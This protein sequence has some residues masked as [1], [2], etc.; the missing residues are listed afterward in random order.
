MGEPV[1][2]VAKDI[3]SILLDSEDA[4]GEPVLPK[5]VFNISLAGVLAGKDTTGDATSW[6]MHLLHENP[7]VENKLR[8]EL[9][10]KVPKL[11]EDE[12][13]VPPM[14]ELD[15]I[16]YLEATIREFE[17]Q[18]AGPVRHAAL[19]SRHSVPGR[20]LR[21]QGHGHDAVV[22]RFGAAAECLG[23]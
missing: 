2:P 18:T 1:G 5:D 3:V 23:P 10:A 4:T 13:Y 12:S 7:R 8:A 20:H 16:T 11:A 14:E 22:S 6:L 9:L 21:P 17:A 15:A 19:H